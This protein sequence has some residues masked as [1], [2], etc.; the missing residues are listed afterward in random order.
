MVGRMREKV[1][2]AAEGRVLEV[3]FGSGRNLPYYDADKVERLF[4]L[5]PD[6]NMVRLARGRLAASPIAAVEI[7]GLAGE[8]IPLEDAS[9]DTVVV[10][11]TLCT[12]PDV[13]A[14]L[15]QMRRVITPGG[16]L[17]FVEHG[18]HARPRVAALQRRIEPAWTPLADGCHLT[19]HPPSLLAEAGFRVAHEEGTPPHAPIAGALAP[20]A[21][22]H[23]W[24][25][26][27][28]A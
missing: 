28:P 2:P 15:A 23:Y 12:I 13:A 21:A 5:E 27:R 26:A 9:I 11:Y 4:A 3:G 8:A 10:T 22:Y 25:A 14:A 16:R 6:P 19:R 20:F 24:G 18:R 1:V 17:L 7:L